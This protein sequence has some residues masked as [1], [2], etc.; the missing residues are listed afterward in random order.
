MQLPFLWNASFSVFFVVA[1]L[2]V[3]TVELCMCVTEINQETFV[4]LYQS[5][6]S[7]FDKIEMNFNYK[8][9]SS[10]KTSCNLTMFGC[11]WHKRSNCI[12][13]VQ[14]MRLLTIFT[15]YSLPVC[16]CR[17]FLHTEN[18]PSPKMPSFKFI[19]YIWKNGEFWKQPKCMV[20]KQF[21]SQNYHQSKYVPLHLH[22]ITIPFADQ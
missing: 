12:S 19:S 17:H 11:P 10:W 5:L 8:P 6:L 7:V 16:L 14:S 3:T 21:C 9:T 20:R 4:N 22:I 13:R 1:H 15:A 18:V 2:P